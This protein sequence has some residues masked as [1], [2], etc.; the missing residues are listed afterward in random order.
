[1]AL[2]FGF[3]TEPCNPAA[4]LFHTSSPL[5][6][7]LWPHLWNWDDCT[8]WQ[9]DGGVKWVRGWKASPRA[10]AALPLIFIISLAFIKTLHGEAGRMSSINLILSRGECITIRNSCVGHTMFSKNYQGRFSSQLSK[11]R[12]PGTKPNPGTGCRAKYLQ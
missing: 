7:S 11:R 6:A 2:H 4:G 5:T 8:F 10:A 3:S 12:L 9:D 1:M